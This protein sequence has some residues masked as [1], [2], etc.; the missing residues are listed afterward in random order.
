MNPAEPILEAR[1]I[2]FGFR[3]RPDFLGPL[4]LMIRPGQFWGV[5]GPNGAGKTT[6]LRLLAGIVRPSAGAIL[7]EGV[8]LNAM[9]AR[10]R[11]RRL[12]Y[13][14]QRLIGD[15]DASALEKTLHA[16]DLP[17]TPMVSPV[18]ASGFWDQVLYPSEPA[19]AADSAFHRIEVKYPVR[20]IPL[21]GF[22][23]AFGNEIGMAI[24]FVLITIVAAF[25]LK[26]VFGVTI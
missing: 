8:P 7:L 9:P 18:R 26:G 14:P 3:E 10:D 20:E 15:P 1:G 6:L 17:G 19:F 5:I 4:D 16:G 12:A 23:L 2:R 21:L 22:D 13:L 24:T 25:G 11:A